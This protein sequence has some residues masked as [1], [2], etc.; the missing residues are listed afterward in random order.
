MIAD[1]KLKSKN[2]KANLAE[3]EAHVGR[4]K[5]A[6]SFLR[7]MV[8]LAPSHAREVLKVIQLEPSLYGM[9]DACYAYYLLTSIV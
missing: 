2:L 4:V 9:G 5:A 3:G 6:L 8:S 7:G 1:F